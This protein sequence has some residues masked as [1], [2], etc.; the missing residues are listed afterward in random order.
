MLHFMML[1]AI[2]HL[3]GPGRTRE[4]RA[5]TWR[6]VYDLYDELGHPPFPLGFAP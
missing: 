1:A 4:D 3:R 2:S 5:E 6:H